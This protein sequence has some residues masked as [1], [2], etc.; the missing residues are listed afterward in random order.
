MT[1]L[2]HR[3]H[4]NTLYRL[5]NRHRRE[6]IISRAL[7]HP[8]TEPGVQRQVSILH[9]ELPFANTAQW[10]SMYLKIGRHQLRRWSTG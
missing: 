7:T 6:I 2:N 4:N 9:H 3:T 1:R 8:L 5:T 10:L